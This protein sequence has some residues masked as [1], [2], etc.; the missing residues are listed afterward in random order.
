MDESP[1]PD[2]APHGSVTQWICEVKNGNSDAAQR[3]WDRYF[4]RLVGLAKRKLYLVPRQE[5]DEEDVAIQA[6]GSFFD[7]ARLG[8]FP[9]LQDRD[10]LWS[11]LAS[12]I[13]HKA[14]K[15]RSRHQASKRGGGQT[16]IDL[17]MDAEI[18]ADPDFAILDSFSLELRELLA[19]LQDERLRTIAT[20]VLH[21]FTNAEI[22]KKMEVTQRTIE[23]KRLIIRRRW[24]KEFGID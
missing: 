2:L 18:A 14:L 1:I 7:K 9:R 11:L 23:R 10:D 13:E 3:L 5:S 8:R 22:A 16:R 19:S 12:I 15:V 4:Q 17:D 24:S 21:G 6:L 20:L